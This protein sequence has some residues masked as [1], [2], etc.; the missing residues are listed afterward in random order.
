MKIK[1]NPEDFIV[2]EIYDLA[3]IGSEGNFAIYR[4]EKRGIS[5]FEAAGRLA[6]AAGVDTDAV[7][8]AGLKDKQ[9]LTVQVMSVESREDA[10]LNEMIGATRGMAA[11]LLGFSTEA[12]TSERLL[13]NEFNITIRD[14]TKEESLQFMEG[15]AEA[16]EFGVPNY[17]DDQRFG[18]ARSGK[19]FP[20]RELVLGRDGEALRLLVA[21]PATIDTGEHLARKQQLAAAWGNWRECLQIS[22]GWHEEEVFRHLLNT[23]ADFRG[24]LKFVPRRERLMQLFAYQSSLWNRA[25]DRL[26]RARCA[27]TVEMESELGAL[28]AWSAPATDEMQYFETLDMRL[29]AAGT[30]CKDP[31]AQAALESAAQEDGLTIQQLEIRGLRGFDFREEVRPAVLAPDAVEAGDPVVDELH[32][33]KFKI[34]L[35]LTLSKGGYATLVLKRA[36]AHKS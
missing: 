5:T 12:A 24:A 26:V 2:R 27:R 4:V 7:R 22:R 32:R 11:K 18:A 20:A 34:Q 14:L 31:A 28:A 8:F 25:L 35:K 16:A 30:N 1:E 3:A 10:S 21:T 6:R 36:A 29:P 19:G 9:A 23:P 33:G 15:L 13:G 17:F